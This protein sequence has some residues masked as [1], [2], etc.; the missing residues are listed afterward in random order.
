M[1]NEQKNITPIFDMM[2]SRKDKEKLLKQRGVMVWFTGLSG[3]GKSTLAIALEQELQSRGLLC[4]ILDGDNI[5][6]G[7][8]NN[9][10]FSP[11][12]RKENIRRI[13]EV[14]KLFV[15]TGIITIAAFISPNNDLREM[16]SEIIGKED[17]LEIYVSTPIEE[18]ERRDVKGLYAKARKGEIK[19][20]TG[21]SAP[22][23]PPVHASL[24]LDTSLLTIEESV[25]ML[26]NVVLPKVKQ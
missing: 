25:N 20:F 5:R 3:S 11:E 18:C 7:I 2:L 22:F 6:T 16:A 14:G 17:F 4:R 12:D 1:S 26:L 13:A 15:D 23:E 10:G 9:L 24:T 19:E 21:V 8:N